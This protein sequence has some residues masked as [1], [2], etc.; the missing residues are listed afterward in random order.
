MPEY[1]KEKTLLSDLRKLGCTDQYTR[2]GGVNL[3]KTAT[4]VPFTVADPHKP[5][6]PSGEGLYEI[7]YVKDLLDKVKLMSDPKAAPPFAVNKDPRPPVF[8]VSQRTADHELD[9]YRES[10]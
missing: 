7:N 8:T 4:G 2:K 1:T 5:L 9:D 6:H 10:E 3:W